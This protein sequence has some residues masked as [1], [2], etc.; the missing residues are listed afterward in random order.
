MKRDCVG[1]LLKP[2][3]VKICVGVIV[4]LFLFTIFLQDKVLLL[5]W[6]QSVVLYLLLL[7]LIFLRN[8]LRNKKEKFLMSLS[9]E[10]LWA[11]MQDFELEARKRKFYLFRLYWRDLRQQVSTFY[12]E[13]FY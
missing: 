2:R 3:S 1:F 12:K 11:L 8:G 7:F 10:T 9:P 5:L 6:F 13:R 4:L